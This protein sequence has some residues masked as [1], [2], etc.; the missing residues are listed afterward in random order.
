MIGLCL[1]SLK[2]YVLRGL[3]RVRVR[4]LQRGL[5]LGF[6]RDKGVGSRVRV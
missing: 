5:D 6:I 1:V 4:D 2:V 3:D